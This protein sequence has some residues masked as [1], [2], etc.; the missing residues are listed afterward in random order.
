MRCRW[1]ARTR[2]QTPRICRWRRCHRCAAMRAD[3]DHAAVTLIAFFLQKVVVYPLQINAAPE[4]SCQPGQQPRK[5]HGG[6][7]SGQIRR[8]VWMCAGRVIHGC[9]FIYP[10]GSTRL[11]S[12]SPFLGKCICNCCAAIFSMRAGM[13]KV[14]CSSC[15][16]PHSTSIC[17]ACSFSFCSSTNNLRALCCEVTT[18]S[19]HSTTA[20]QQQDVQRVAA[21]PHRCAPPRASPR[22][23]RADCLHLRLSGAHRL[24][25]QV[26]LAPAALRRRVSARCA[27]ACRPRAMSRMK[28]FT[29][30]SSSE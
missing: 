2:R 1:A 25:D 11:N 3:L 20:S 6:A 13:A 23:A 19:A 30:R 26:Q 21:T 9:L 27:A 5:Q 28:C 17:C 8:N 12:I 22:C 16:W 10:S 15:S 18:L 24:A 14:L 4:Q 7:P 29:M